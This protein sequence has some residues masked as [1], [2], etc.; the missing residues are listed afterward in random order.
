[1]EKLIKLS[2]GH[3]IVI[4]DSEIKENQ[5]YCNNKV[6]FLSDDKFD[7][8]NNPNQNKNNKKVT[9]STKPI[10]EP[11][12]NDNRKE[13]IYIEPLDLSYIKELVREMDVKKGVD[14]ATKNT[15]F[16]MLSY[17]SDAK[18]GVIMGYKQALED[19]K[20]KRFTE[21]DMINCY[22]KAFSEGTCFG[23]SPIGYKYM[24]SMEYIESFQKEVT[25][26][27]VYWDNEQL[28]LK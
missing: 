5:W 7:E 16:D 10:E 1:M 22:K 6:L 26:W 15:R 9:H 18:Q 11:Y 25:E 8:G 17:S 23:A 13:F 12:I 19:N 14:R 4:D 2:E 3:Y 27:D 20:E 21:A 28:K 24:T